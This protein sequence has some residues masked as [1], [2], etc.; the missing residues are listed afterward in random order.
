ML[1]LWELAVDARNVHP[2][3]SKR[4]EVAEMLTE[5]S[6]RGTSG[7]ELS[8]GSTE[9]GWVLKVHSCY[10]DGEVVILV[11]S[12]AN[13][14]VEIVSDTRKREQHATLQH[15]CPSCGGGEL[16]S[17]CEVCHMTGKVY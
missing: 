13:L 2:L 3:P 16:M 8:I 7:Q 15:P 11:P 6:A 14:P 5:L 17:K 4:R 10:H 12:D 1:N 9:R